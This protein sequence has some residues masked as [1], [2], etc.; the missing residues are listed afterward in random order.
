M[1]RVKLKIEAA[2]GP[3]ER[4]GKASTSLLADA[5]LQGMLLLDPHITV[6]THVFGYFSWL[7]CLS[8]HHF[9]C[10]PTMIP[11]WS[12]S[13]RI[14]SITSNA[15]GSLFEPC[16]TH[17]AVFRA[18]KTISFRCGRCLTNSAYCQH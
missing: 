1:L 14:I 11:V 10:R 16:N 3:I 18:S 8:S 15:T 5:E 12:V 7:F 17:L 9:P 13:L 2:D 6:P 4:V